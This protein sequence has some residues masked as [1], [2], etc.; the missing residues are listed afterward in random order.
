MAKNTKSGSVIAY[1]TIP[2]TY[3]G[4]VNS[5]S[6]AGVDITTRPFGRQISADRFFSASDVIAHSDIGGGFVTVLENRPV[7]SYYG[8]I[9][10]DKG[11]IRVI[12]EGR[13]IVFNNANGVNIQVH[14]DVND[15]ASSPE[16]KTARRN[17]DK[18]HTAIGRI[19]EKSG[20]SSK[21]K[22]KDGAKKKKK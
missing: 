12:T 20:G 11:S 3:E 17:T 7:S 15:D 10:T 1:A 22:S 13:E 6:E 4:H 9:A 19:E 8:D 18:L 2:V 16:A 14:F 5:V 21:K